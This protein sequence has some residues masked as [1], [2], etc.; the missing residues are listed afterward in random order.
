MAAG[1]HTPGHRRPDGTE[2]HKLTPG[3]YARRGE[4]WWACTPNGLTGN[5]GAHDVTEHDDGTITVR[6]SILVTTPSSGA[7]WHGFLEQGKWRE[8]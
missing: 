6:P 2:V 1:L 8:V 5:L 3:E 4:R 7:S